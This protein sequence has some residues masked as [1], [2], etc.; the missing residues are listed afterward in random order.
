VGEIAPVRHSYAST[1]G[2]D[3]ET[4]YYRSPPPLLARKGA[5]V[6][7]IGT[8]FIALYVVFALPSSTLEG[9]ESTIEDLI[10]GD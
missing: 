9:Q 2:S 6:Q 3:E 4:T 1:C 7:T 5:E 10:E 8:T